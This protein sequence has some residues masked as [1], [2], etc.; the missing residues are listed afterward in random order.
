M[1]EESR[2]GFCWLSPPQLRSVPSKPECVGGGSAAKRNIH[3]DWGCLEEA[4]A[5]TY[6]WLYLHKGAGSQDPLLFWG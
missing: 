4:E 3:R 2:K 6:T 5:G 1:L